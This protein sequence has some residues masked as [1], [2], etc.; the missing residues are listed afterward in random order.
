MDPYPSHLKLKE[1]EKGKSVFADKDFA[2][3]EFIIQF[4]G[5]IYS[6]DQYLKLV[7]PE[8]NHF[9]QIDNDLF[10]GPTDTIDDYINH[11]CNPNCGLKYI[12]TKVLL[13]AIKR[14]S[15]GDE[16]S[17]DYSTTMDEDFWEMKC[18]CGEKICRGMIRD[19][20]YLPEAQQQRY[21]SLGI[22]PDFILNKRN[23][24]A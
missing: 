21:I 16:I 19:F 18:C 5:D 11:S 22:V 14:I 24:I 10:I 7:N 6:K 9:L 1:T 15:K 12:G 17:F 4:S 8:N 13:F 2:A 23:R 3:G 20:K